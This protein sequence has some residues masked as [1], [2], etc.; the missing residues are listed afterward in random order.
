M[1]SAPPPPAPGVATSAK[2]ALAPPSAAEQVAESIAARAEVARSH[3]PVDFYMRL[4]PPDLGTVHVYL[5]ATETSLSAH[6]VV[7]NV[8]TRMTIESQLPQLRL[9]L[10]EAGLS[11]GGFDVS[12]Q[13]SG[14]RQSGRSWQEAPVAAA[15]SAI[16]ALSGGPAQRTI[17]SGAGL[18]QLDVLV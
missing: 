2:E 17:V 1:P 18:S 3:G 5:R 11:L 13:R 15:G 10:G 4:D 8:S 9:K 16:P 12:Q 14:S 7:T 6:L